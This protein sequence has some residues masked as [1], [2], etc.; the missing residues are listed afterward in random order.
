MTNAK[1]QHQLYNDTFASRNIK[2][3]PSI[4]SSELI[5]KNELTNGKNVFYK[6]FLY[7]EDRAPRKNLAIWINELTNELDYIKDNISSGINADKLSRLMNLTSLVHC[8]MGNI[9]DAQ[10]ICYKQI[11]YFVRLSKDDISLLH[12]CI[13]PWINLARIDR[14]LNRFDQAKEKLEI[15]KLLD[16]DTKKISILHH[17][18]ERS[19]LVD[20]ING[21]LET[22]NVVKTCS[23]FDVIKIYLTANRYQE[24][25]DLAENYLGDAALKGIAYEAAIIGYISMKNTKK[26][27]DVAQ[28][29]LINISPK[30]LHIFLFRQAELHIIDN[31]KKFEEI[32]FKL[33]ELIKYYEGC[34]AYIQNAVFSAKVAGQFLKYGFN[35]LANDSLEIAI[36]LAK[37]SNDEL[38]I[39]ECLEG[40]VKF[41]DFG[42]YKKSLKTVLEN[43][44]YISVINKYSMQDKNNSA[45]SF[46]VLTKNANLLFNSLQSIL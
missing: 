36:L 35:R 37:R 23:F 6:S 22:K 7:P 33:F 24:M 19:S 45:E 13:Q 5:D 8:S 14:I 25:V 43:T 10:T 32:F 30:L 44:G 38:L 28:S 15:F 42:I 11:E 29:A 18:I 40:L 2:S 16:G 9:E 46:I 39:I 34:N 41:D 4:I 31:N 21:H 27:F 20:A 12:Y 26:A 1:K 3:S 17:Q